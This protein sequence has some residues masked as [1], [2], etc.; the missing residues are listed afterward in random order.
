MKHL[1]LGVEHSNMNC[2]RCKKDTNVHTMSMFNTQEICI[3]CKK[4]EQRHPQYDKARD[5]E[6]E[7]VRN[8]NYNFEG[9]GLPADL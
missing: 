8:G 7:Q 9:I 5:A 1:S 2:P 4:I 3:P 6:F